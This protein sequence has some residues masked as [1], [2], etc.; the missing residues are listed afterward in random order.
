MAFVGQVDFDAQEA[1]EYVRRKLREWTSLESVLVNM[2]H[3][4][5]ELAYRAKQAGREDLAEQAKNV[6][7]NLNAINQNYSKWQG[8]LQTVQEQVPG[9]R[10]IWIP[11]AIA[12]TVI[13]L[14]GAMYGIFRK[15]TAEE[16][17]L[18]MIED[19]V[20]TAEEAAGLRPRG[21]TD[22]GELVRLGLYGTLTLIGFKV[23]QEA[24][25]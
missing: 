19:G 4:A 16:K 6:I 11:A 8:V 23:F 2:M 15:V 7:R 25:R 3:T 20:I 22:L 9:L 5:A 12:A 17:M 14:A 24:S 10:G 21:T 13:A 1:G 18:Q